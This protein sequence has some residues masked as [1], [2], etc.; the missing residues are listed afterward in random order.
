LMLPGLAP[1]ADFLA[2]LAALAAGWRLKFVLVRRAA[3]NQGF[4]LPQLPV[5]GGH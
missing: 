3:Y 2:G 5:R 4:S 1:G